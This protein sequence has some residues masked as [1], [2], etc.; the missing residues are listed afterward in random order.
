MSCVGRCL[1]WSYLLPTACLSKS[2]YFM[3]YLKMLCQLHRFRLKGTTV[4][5]EMGRMWKEEVQPRVCL[6]GQNNTQEQKI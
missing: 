4:Y 2:L 3:A 1:W 5:D 6:E